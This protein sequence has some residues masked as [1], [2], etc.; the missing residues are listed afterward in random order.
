MDDKIY[1]KEK[2]LLSD[3]SGV[4]TVEIMLILVVLI[5]LAIIFREEIV[6]LVNKLW[7]SINGNARKFM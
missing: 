7:T 3:N 2:F 6:N 4:T 1:K 5:A